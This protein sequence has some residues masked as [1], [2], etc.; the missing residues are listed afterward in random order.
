MGDNSCPKSGQTLVL[1]IQ[2]QVSSLSSE[3]SKKSVNLR[4]Y[5][6]KS[7]TTDT[8]QLQVL[9]SVVEQ[10]SADDFC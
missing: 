1:T 5:G 4:V 6:W 8:V 10:F 2:E 3:C 9:T 7:T